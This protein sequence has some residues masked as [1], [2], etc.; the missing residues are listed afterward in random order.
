[1]RFT[2]EFYT[3]AEGKKPAQKFLDELFE[4][5]KRLW[6]QTIA[7]LEKIKLREYHKEPLSKALGGNLWETRVQSGRDILRI[8]YTFAKGRKIILLYGFIKKTQKTP[9]RELAIAQQRLR[10]IVRR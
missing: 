5:N 7:G 10:Q 4:R 3:S 8:I 6:A 1:M 9:V 2:I